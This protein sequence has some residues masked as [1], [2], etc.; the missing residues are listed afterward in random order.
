MLYFIV[1][2]Y[3]RFLTPIPAPYE[4]RI[5][6]LIG[7]HPPEIGIAHARRAH[8]GPGEGMR[9]EEKTRFRVLTIMRG[10][11]RFVPFQLPP[12]KMI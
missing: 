6:P 9:R 5:L 12:P 2:L 4:T 7:A 3:I 8:A 11:A 10:S 1:S